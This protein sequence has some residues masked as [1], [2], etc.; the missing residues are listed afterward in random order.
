MKKFLFSTSSSALAQSLGLLALRLMFGLGMLFAH[1][2]GKMMSYGD[3]LDSFPD[4]LGIGSAASLTATVFAEVVCAFL[5]SIGLLTRGALIPLIFT[6][7]VAAFIVHGN[8]PFSSKEMALLYL[9]GY[10][11]IFLSGPGKFSLDHQLR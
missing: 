8:D 9:T 6:M 3:K 11:V 4:P 2:W 7:L 1:G 5:V 10:G